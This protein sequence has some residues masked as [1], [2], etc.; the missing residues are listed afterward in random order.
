MTETCNAAGIEADI[1]DPS[2][3]AAHNDAFRQHFGMESAYPVGVPSSKALYYH[4][5]LVTPCLHTSNSPSPRKQVLMLPNNSFRG[6]PE[7]RYRIC[8]L[9]RV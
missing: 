1:P 6:V 5:A 9:I 4:C 3:V 7:H 2:V 8:I